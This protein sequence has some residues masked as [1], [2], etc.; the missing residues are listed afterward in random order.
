[1]AIWQ[2]V[3]P[4]AKLQLY[5]KIGCS[6]VRNLATGVLKTYLNIRE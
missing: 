4:L 6:D 3:L 2:L 1:M 5:I